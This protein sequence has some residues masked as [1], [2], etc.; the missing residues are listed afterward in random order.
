[1]ISL[2]N[3]KQRGFSMVETL[4]A[5][6]IMSFGLI[7]LVKFQVTM[8]GYGGLIKSK[9][10]AISLAQEKMEDIRNL[11]ISSQYTAGLS[12][13]S[14]TNCSVS[15]YAADTTITKVNTNFTRCYQVVTTAMD[16]TA[17]PPVPG[18]KSITTRVVWTDTA[19]TQQSVELNSIIAWSDPRS[20]ASLAT[21]TDPSTG[22][23]TPSGG[24]V[25]GS[26]TNNSYSP[27]QFTNTG[28]DNGDGTSTV[29]TNGI[30]ELVDNTTGEVLLTTV[31]GVALVTIGGRVFIEGT[32]ADAL[33]MLD[34]AYIAVSDAGYCVRQFNSPV[35]TD[36][37]AYSYYEYKCYVGVG[38]YGNLGVVRTVIS[39]N[40]LNNTFKSSST[41][42]GDPA[43]TAQLGAARTYRGY[44]T[45]LD[46]LNPGD[47]IGG[48][49]SPTYFPIG[50]TSNV[51]GNHDYLIAHIS[52]GS[53]T[54]SDCVT[55]M[56][57]T[58]SFNTNPDD[59]YCLS[60]TCPGVLT[61]STLNIS[62][63]FSVNEVASISSSDGSCSITGPNYN[64]VITYA[65]GSTWTGTVDVTP[66]AGYAVCSSDPM[67]FTGLSADS[68]GND[69]TTALSSC[70][71]TP[72]PSTYTAT[73]TGDID[74]ADNGNPSWAVSIDNGGTCTPAS[75]NRTGSYTCTVTGIAGA[76]T[77]SITVSFNSNKNVCSTA[78]FTRSVSSASNNVSVLTFVHA[79]GA[80]P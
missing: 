36:S 38:W 47:L 59:F 70:V 79:N 52:G 25:L 65:S 62:G 60:A 78:S 37:G 31:S 11:I 46:P 4:V 49:A 23:G 16:L 18:Y 35:S 40:N 3:S 67:S 19:N 80:C 32:N 27:D 73:F 10:V 48:N 41:C 51:S 55:E 45:R 6:V 77:P 29:T 24:A 63:S 57:N 9:T 20:S 50:I 26:P 2:M 17:T 5:L 74:H 68:S 75:G 30:T 42:V 76:A 7:A 14:G 61:T 34:G 54:D 33:T 43:S 64:C 1:M 13:T 69:I 56:S 44:E 58:S 39:P 22:F 21:N 66:A 15:G 72:P 8:V 28:N 71:V 12:D 53:P